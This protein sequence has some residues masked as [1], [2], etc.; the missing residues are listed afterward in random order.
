MGADGNPWRP[1]GFGDGEG[2]GRLIWEC[3]ERGE[4]REKVCERVCRE[5]SFLKKRP[6][7]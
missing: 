3:V 6:E 7:R 2:K 1:G 4:E 5:V